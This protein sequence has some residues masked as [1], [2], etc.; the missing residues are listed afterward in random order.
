M[1]NDNPTKLSNI[2]QML[3]FWPRNTMKL[4]LTLMSCAYMTFLFVL[5]HK[6][7][8]QLFFSSLLV[9]YHFGVTCNTGK[10]SLWRRGNAMKTSPRIFTRSL[11][12]LAT[13]PSFLAS[14]NTYTS[15][16]VSIT[17]YGLLPR[18]FATHELRSV[19]GCIF[20]CLLISKRVQAAIMHYGQPS[21]TQVW[22]AGTWYCSRPFQPLHFSRP[23]H[24]QLCN[25]SIAYCW[26]NSGV[27][28]PS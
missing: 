24:I 20:N 5:H 23:I 25:S 11:C 2:F 13:Q 4:W 3:W 8:L 18:N 28:W 17:Y 7:S 1:K 22:R 19:I 15:T 14:Q 10:R 6:I 16:F 12:P 27:Y 26:E 21:L 9:T